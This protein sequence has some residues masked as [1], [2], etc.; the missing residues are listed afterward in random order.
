MPE[1]VSWTIS[2][3]LALTRGG[4]WSQSFTWKAV[5]SDRRAP[6]QESRL[7]SAERSWRAVLQRTRLPDLLE[8]SWRVCYSI[9]HSN[10]TEG[11]CGGARIGLGALRR[12]QG[13]WQVAANCRSIWRLPATLCE[14]PCAHTFEQ[15]II[16]ILSSI[17]SCM[18]GWAGLRFRRTFALT[19]QNSHTKGK[20]PN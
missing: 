15:S 3:P 4:T 20:S 6:S 7:C 13:I 5:P 1:V 8:D 9:I 19:V 10:I 11:P 2:D 14:A 18:S 17:S 16:R 12:F